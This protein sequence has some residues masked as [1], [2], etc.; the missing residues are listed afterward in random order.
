MKENNHASS[1]NPPPSSKRRKLIADF[2]SGIL[3]SVAVGELQEMAPLSEPSGPGS[4]R[5]R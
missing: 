5:S 1:S 2:P 3:L 4:S